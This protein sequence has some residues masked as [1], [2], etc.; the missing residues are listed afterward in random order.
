MLSELYE[1]LGYPQFKSFYDV[2]KVVDKTITKAQVK[3]FIDKQSVSE[4]YHRR[5][6]KK[7]GMILALA[8]SVI[9]Q[10]DLIDMKDFSGANKNNR[11][12]AVL[13]D[14]YSRKMWAYPMKDKSAEVSYSTLHTFLREN[15]C[16]EL[17]TDDGKEWKGKFKKL[18]NDLDITHAPINVS[19]D[20]HKALGIVDRAIRTLKGKIYKAFAVKKTANWMDILPTMVSAYNQKEHSF[21]HSTPNSLWEHPTPEYN[22]KLLDT[23]REIYSNEGHSFKVG[24][25]VRVAENSLFHRGFEG[26]YSK[27]TYKVVKVSRFNLTL[28]DGRKVPADECILAN[29]P[30]TVETIEVDV[31]KKDAKQK[32]ALRREGLKPVPE[33]REQRSRKKNE[34]MNLEKEAVN[35][36]DSAKAEVVKR[37]RDAEF[38][39]HKGK[40]ADFRIQFRLPK[41][42]PQ[43][44][45]VD[46]FIYDGFVVPELYQYLRDN[47]QVK[48]SGL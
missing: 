12:I 28:D 25:H 8:P 41:K 14:V 2:V 3:E 47:R 34:V 31:S 23:A 38:L 15:K 11:Y 27:D 44:A 43:W 7:N 40:G 30:V 36:R 45:G 13:I 9:Y 4:I 39:G 26:T 6:E 17:M 37:G 46:Y 20:G 42:K 16:M 10:A 18:L 19:Q 1:K 24:D 29:V 33:A 21:T 32:R 48:N 5:G 35:K 22:T